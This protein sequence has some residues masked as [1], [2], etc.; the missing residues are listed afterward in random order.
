MKVVTA[1]GEVCV[2][3]CGAKKVWKN[4]AILS[5]I[6]R[7]TC[8]AY[9]QNSAGYDLKNLFIGSE[10]TLGF[11]AELT[12]RLHPIPTNV[13]SGVS[14]F[15]TLESATDAVVCI[16]ASGVPVAKCEILDPSAINAFNLYTSEIADMPTIPHLFIELQDSTAKGLE[17]QEE[18]VREI[19]VDAGCVEG[20]TD[21]R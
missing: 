3:G 17:G 9:L 5:F 8:F 13:T 11:I 6:A 10:G 12:L 20:S 2:V 19:L 18:L 16:L 14:R 21:F 4:Q 15:T 1:D 7:L